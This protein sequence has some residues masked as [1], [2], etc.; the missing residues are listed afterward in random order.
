[1][2][3]RV[4]LKSNDLRDEIDTQQPFDTSLQSRIIA[5]ELTTD[6]YHLRVL[7]ELKVQPRETRDLTSG[8]SSRPSPL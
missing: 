4:F 2:R 5:H 7:C 8:P 3:Q 1:M 6:H